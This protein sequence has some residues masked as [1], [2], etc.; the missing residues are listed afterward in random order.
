MGCTLNKGLVMNDKMR[1]FKE[2]LI[3]CNREN[4]LD[5]IEL[6]KIRRQRMWDLAAYFDFSGLKDRATESS[7]LN[8]RDMILVSYLT[9]IVVLE[10]LVRKIEGSFAINTD[11]LNN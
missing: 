4:G 2:L 8:E 1:E 11:Y 3:E 9:S 6:F 5:S 10:S 7:P